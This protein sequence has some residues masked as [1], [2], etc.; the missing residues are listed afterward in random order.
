MFKP[1]TQPATPGSPAASSCPAPVAPAPVRAAS[2]VHR[3]SAGT[4]RKTEG[5]VD[6]C[7]DA[8]GEVTGDEPIGYS[9]T[10]SKMFANMVWLR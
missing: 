9:S 5:T 6:G 3:T 2:T 8:A 7:R 10:L 4:D 1:I